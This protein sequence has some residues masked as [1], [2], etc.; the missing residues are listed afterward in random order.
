MDVRA[1]A[2]AV[3]TIV[4]AGLLAPATAP[5]ATVTMGADAGPAANTTIQFR[6][7]R[8]EGNRVTVRLRRK[9]VLLRDDGVDRLRFRDLGFGRCDRIGRRTLV[10]PRAPVIAI[11]RD[12]ADTFRAT[13]SGHGHDHARRHPRAL[14]EDYTDTEG[15]VVQTTIVDAG[16]GD[17]IVL[18]SRFDDVI[19]PGPGRDFVNARGGGDTVYG[20]RDDQGDHLGGGPGIDSVDF[21][22][23]TRPLS[24][25]LADGTA[26]GGGHTDSIGGFERVHGG[27]RADVLRGTST[28]DALYGE[29]GRDVLIGRGG[30]DLLVGDSPILTRAWPNVLRGGTGG[31][32]I[33]ARGYA[34][35]P[36]PSHAQ[37]TS[38]VSCGHGPDL[39][40]GESDDRLS[41]TCN[42]T[43]FRIP[44]SSGYRPDERDLYGAA[45]RVWPVH[46]ADALTYE[47]PCPTLRQEP[48]A[49][50]SGSITLSSPPPAGEAPGFVYG[51]A[52]F[53]LEPGERGQVRVEL[54]PAGKAAIAD[55]DPIDVRVDMNLSQGAGNEPER[56]FAAWEQV[57]PAGF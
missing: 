26:S 48:N 8:G 51:S 19:S 3:G 40:L 36:P 2:A 47:V 27:R 1:R 13:P 6:A 53:D 21:S 30:N 24:V 45:M 52:P 5:A 32:L 9:T 17:D 28:G 50:C 23:A 34:T 55:G 39:V 44:N 22:S 43:V 16:S 54:T 49:G 18:G 14:A 15:A 31:D 20:D 7:A 11:L 37:L 29:E 41:V 25:D 35:A 57:V 46:D 56:A 10:C 38:R 42:R 12:R 33:D 4:M